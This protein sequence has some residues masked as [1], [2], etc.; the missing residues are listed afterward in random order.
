MAFRAVQFSIPSHSLFTFPPSSDPTTVL[1]VA[2]DSTISFT[3]PSS[4]PSSSY[5]D[6]LDARVPITFSC[7]YA[8]TATALNVY[9][10]SRGHKPWKISKTKTFFYLMVAHNVLLSVYS[11]WTSVGMFGALKRSIQNPT[12]PAG[13][14]GMVDSLCKIHGSSGFENAITYRS[15]LS[16]WTYG[17][18]SNLNLPETHSPSPADRGRLWNEGLAFYGWFFYLSK[19]YEVL[20]TA[21]ILSKG[22]NASFLQV[23]HHIGA[24]LCMWA[25]IRYMSPPIWIPVLLNSGIHALMV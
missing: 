4:I 10:K 15:E 6:S 25:G 18:F 1:P 20:D 22:K 19:F 5:Y 2:N 7:I 8:A 14:V 24:M 12:G 13:L 23:Y 16:R 3:L 11:A 9:N 17:P 21:I